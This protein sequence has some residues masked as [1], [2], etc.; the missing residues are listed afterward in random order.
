MGNTLAGESIKEIKGE[1]DISTSQPEEEE[2]TRIQKENEYKERP[3]CHEE[4]EG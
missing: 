1:K 3:A 4:K 2:K